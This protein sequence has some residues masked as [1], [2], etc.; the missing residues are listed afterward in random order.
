MIGVVSGATIISDSGL[1][2]AAAVVVDLIHSTMDTGCSHCE[3]VDSGVTPGR[4]IPSVSPDNAHEHVRYKN[5]LECSAISVLI[6]HHEPHL[7][8]G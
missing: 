1:G 6:G 2:R 7:S 4:H 5:I 8:F 3:P